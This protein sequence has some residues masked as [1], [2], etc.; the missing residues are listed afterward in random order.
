[1]DDAVHNCKHGGGIW[2]LEKGAAP[3]LGSLE[4]P[5]SGDTDP[6]LPGGCSHCGASSLATGRHISSLILCIFLSGLPLAVVYSL[7]LLFFQNTNQLLIV[8]SLVAISLF[9]LVFSINHLIG[10]RAAFYS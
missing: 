1:M 7:V 3:L 6:P 4:Q 10:R 8:W 5:A 9:G 2:K